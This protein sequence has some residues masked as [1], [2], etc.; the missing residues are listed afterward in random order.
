MEIGINNLR[1][2]TGRCRC[3]LGSSGDRLLFTHG[4]YRKSAS[5]T[6]PYAIVYDSLT[7]RDLAP[8]P[9]VCRLPS[10]T[11]QTDASGYASA[12]G[13]IGVQRIAVDDPSL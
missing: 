5:G 2:H 11:G 13:R 10:C 9:A 8:H 3:G 4:K 7:W 1:D 6:Y 12:A